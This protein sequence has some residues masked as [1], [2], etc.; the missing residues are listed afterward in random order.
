M[1][2]EKCKEIW[3]KSC[4]EHPEL[5]ESNWEYTGIVLCDS[6]RKRF[7]DQVARNDIGHIVDEYGEKFIAETLKSKLW[8]FNGVSGTR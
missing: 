2:C 6:C 8:Q 5:P 4:E 1:S 3:D 7:D